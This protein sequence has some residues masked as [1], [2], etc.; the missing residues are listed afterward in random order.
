MKKDYT[1][2]ILIFLSY[3]VKVLILAKVKH[4][5]WFEVDFFK[6]E[7]KIDSTKMYPPE[8]LFSYILKGNKGGL[9]F[10]LNYLIIQKGITMGPI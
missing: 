4:T 10:D 1:L 6:T 7:P 9:F 5:Y 2:W 3:A 8:K